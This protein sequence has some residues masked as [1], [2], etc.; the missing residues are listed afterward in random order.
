MRYACFIVPLLLTSIPAIAGCDLET[1]F[2]DSTLRVDY[3]FG[4]GPEGSRIMLDS[5]SKS[6]GWY[7]KRFNLNRLPLK[8][9][10]TI[11]VMD[12]ESGDTLYVNS[13]SSL[14]Q[15]WV[16]TPEA[17]EIS[18]SFENSFLLPQPKG[19]ADIVV[20]LYDN[21]QQP[22]ATHRHR[23]RP[24]DELVANRA[25]PDYESRYVYRGGDPREAIDV[26]MIAEGYR[27]EEAELFFDDA[28]RMAD[29]IL[30]Y[31]PFASRRERFNFIAVMVPSNESGVSIPL[32][33]DWK[34]TSFGSHYST[35]YSARYLTSPRVRKMHDSLSGLPYEHVMVLVNTDHY[36]GGGIYNSYQMAATHNRHSLPVTVHEF[37]H[38]FGGLADEYF[39]A[40]DED[41]TYPLDVEPWEPNITTL[42]DFKSKWADMLSATTPVS[43]PWEDLG[44][45]REQRMKRKEGDETAAGHPSIGV[46]EGGGYRTK[47]VY[48]PAVT[49]RMRDNYHPTLCP[50]CER[51]VAALIDFY[52]LP[53]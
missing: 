38:S 32:E 5:Q 45:T 8:G 18:R 22:M 36:G 51:S 50:V 23:Y 15:E 34:D 52:T 16:N 27:R 44:G 1:H 20:T 28:K 40:D 12:P 30:S 21:R 4:G 19:E 33:N 48:R 26:A 37:G 53:E 41:D 31:E 7:G 9:N 17:T 43:T 39:Y 46:Y 24:D 11:A 42:V 35:F 49:C 6:A 3:I 29:E 13:F 10:G 14:F 47:G 25:K 2:N